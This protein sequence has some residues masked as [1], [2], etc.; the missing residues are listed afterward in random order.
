MGGVQEVVEEVVEMLVVVVENLEAAL[1]LEVVTIVVMVV[2]VL[3][4]ELNQ[5][6]TG[7]VFTVKVKW[8]GKELLETKEQEKEGGKISAGQGKMDQDKVTLVEAQ[9]PVMDLEQVDLD[10]VDQEEMEEAY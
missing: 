8:V 7:R 9:E 6:L 2:M 10:L 5:V 4:V 3:V 1:E